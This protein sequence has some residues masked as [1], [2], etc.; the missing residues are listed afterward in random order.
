MNPHVIVI[1]GCTASGKG[2]VARC[3][4]ERM[5]AEILSID[6]MKVYRGMDIGT[7]KPS[8][9]DRAAIP[10][11]LVDIVDPWEAFSAARFVEC[12]DQAAAEIHARGR[13]VIAVGGTVLYFKSFYE[14]L[15]AGPSAD[16][17]LRAQLRRRADELDAIR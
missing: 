14:G 15:F 7:A 8:S 9:A 17:S 5:G 1:L 4:A 13:P 11:H 12:A 16:E 2:A 3:L 10:H 6:S